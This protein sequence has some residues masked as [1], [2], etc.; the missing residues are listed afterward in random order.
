ML[1][2]NCTSRRIDLML[3]MKVVLQALKIEFSMVSPCVAMATRPGNARAGILDVDNHRLRARCLRAACES[4]LSNRRTIIA[5][6][7]ERYDQFGFRWAGDDNHFII[8]GGDAASR[9]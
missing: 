6:R 9:R 2:L 3:T 4:R 1:S 5:T 7:F 8:K